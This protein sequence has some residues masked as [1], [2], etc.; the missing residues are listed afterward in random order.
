[1]IDADHGNIA[2]IGPYHPS[3]E[4]VFRNIH[5]KGNI[6]GLGFG[7]QSYTAVS[8]FLRR[9]PEAKIAERFKIKY[10]NLFGLSFKL[11]ETDNVRIYDTE[12]VEQPFADGCPDAVDVIGNYIFHNFQKSLAKVEKKHEHSFAVLHFLWDADLFCGFGIFLMIYLSDGVM[13]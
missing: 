1:M 2:V 11:L 7:K 8:F 3:L 5:P 6:V 13:E 12:P 4:V 9:E 10:G